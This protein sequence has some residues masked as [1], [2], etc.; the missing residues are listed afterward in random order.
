MLLRAL[1]CGR[2]ARDP[3]LA[4]RVIDMLLT[5]DNHVLLHLLSSEQALMDKAGEMI[6]YL[7]AAGFAEEGNLVFAG[8]NF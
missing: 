3:A 7:E 4:S 1:P 8:N 2:I 6:A 5:M